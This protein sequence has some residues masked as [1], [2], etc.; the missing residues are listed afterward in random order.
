LY[1]RG[2]DGISQGLALLDSESDN[3]QSGQA[4]AASRAEFNV[5]AAELSINYAVLGAQILLL[6]QHPRECVRWQEKALAAARRFQVRTREGI[7][8][9]T[10]G[11]AYSD[12]CEAERA[13]KCHEQALLIARD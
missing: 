6:R 11:V 12:L 13:I 7:L 8:L 1:L 4:W 2:S 9:N 5:G 3:I 10:L